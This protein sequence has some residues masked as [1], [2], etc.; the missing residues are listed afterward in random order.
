MLKILVN[1]VTGC[2]NEES[3][4]NVLTLFGKLTSRVSFKKC[5]IYIIFKLLLGKLCL[6]FE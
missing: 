5:L 4:K 3:A 6:R 1:H 2:K